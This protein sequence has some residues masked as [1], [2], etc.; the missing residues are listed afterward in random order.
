MLSSPAPS[1]PTISS[2]GAAS[3]RAPFT[4][5]PV[6]TINARAG[7]PVTVRWERDGEIHEVHPETFDVL[8]AFSQEACDT[9]LSLLEDDGVLI[10][11]EDLVTPP[12]DLTQRATAIPGGS[13]SPSSRT[14]MA[15]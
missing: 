1:R 3:N 6:R 7:E 2:R 13:G 5:I 11:E 9:Y 4:S 10:Y 12:A 15:M 8:V 14:P